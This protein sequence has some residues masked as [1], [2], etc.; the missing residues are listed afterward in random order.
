MGSE[1]SNHVNQTGHNNK[2]QA[3]H[4]TDSE[5]CDVYWHVWTIYHYALLFTLSEMVRIVFKTAVRVCWELCSLHN[6]ESIT[7]QKCITYLNM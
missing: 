4:K 3:I 7:I 6:V 2:S 5:I 1:E